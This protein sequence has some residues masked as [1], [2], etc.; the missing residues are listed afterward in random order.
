MSMRIVTPAKVKRETDQY[1][2]YE[3]HDWQG[4]PAERRERKVLCVGGALNG[5]LKTRTQLQ[6]GEFF[7]RAQRSQTK[8]GYFPYNNQGSAPLKTVWVYLGDNS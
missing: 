5:Q 2:I 7:G 1:I 6:E 3:G 4:K 8:A